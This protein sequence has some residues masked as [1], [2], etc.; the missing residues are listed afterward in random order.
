MLLKYCLD[1][2]QPEVRSA[3]WLLLA[4]LVPSVGGNNHS[5][6]TFVLY[7]STFLQEAIV[8]NIFFKELRILH[9]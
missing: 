3:C 2:M 7:S 1:S 9:V 5:I 8:K 4:L 6:E